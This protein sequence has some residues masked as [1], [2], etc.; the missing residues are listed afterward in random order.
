MARREKA[1]F[2]STFANDFA[3]LSPIWLP[4]NVKVN[5]L[6]FWVAIFPR[7]CARRSAIASV[8]LQ[9]RNERL[10]ILLKKKKFEG[11]MIWKSYLRS[12][13]SSNIWTW[14]AARGFPSN[15]IVLSTRN[16]HFRNQWLIFTLN[17]WSTHRHQRIHRLFFHWHQQ[18]KNY[19]INQ[20][21]SLSLQLRKWKE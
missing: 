7:I 17:F 15:E 13:R 10:A 3:P 11:R 8:I 20:Y 9:K 5:N 12:S 18:N 6:K 21:V 14:S 1:I 19:H 4:V 2:N 16:T